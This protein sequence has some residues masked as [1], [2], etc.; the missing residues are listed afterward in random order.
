ME[1][2]FTF[3][4]RDKAIDIIEQSGDLVKY[5]TTQNVECP[6]LESK[7]IK[8]IKKLGKGAAGA[9]AWS[10]EVPGHGRKEYVAKIFTD[11]LE[12]R[13]LKE[14]D[15]LFGSKTSKTLKEIAKFIENNE[16][17]LADTTIYVNGNDPNRVYNKQNNFVYVMDNA[18]M[19]KNTIPLKFKRFDGPKF[20]TIPVGSYICAE[21]RF[22]EYIIGVLC[23]NIFRSGV[24]L[25]FIDMFGFASCANA[26]PDKIKQ[27]VFMDKIDSTIA[28][29]V[30]VKPAEDQII[31]PNSVL[32]EQTLWKGKKYTELDILCVQTLTA[33]A[34][35]Q[36]HSIQHDD[37]H[38]DNVFL[39]K[40]SKKTEYNNR[41]LIDYP[42]WKH[43]IFDKEIYTPATRWVVKIG[44]FGLSVKYST[45]MVGN[46][47]VLEN[48]YDQ[49][50]GGGSW[51][52][53]WFSRA[54]DV[55]YFLNATYRVDRGSKLVKALLGAALCLPP[56]ASDIDLD[57]E[58]LVALNPNNSRPR[59]NMLKN[60]DVSA[61][62]VTLLHNEILSSFH[63]PS[64]K[65]SNSCTLATII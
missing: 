21:E 29:L 30:F 27:Y 22:S 31:D 44:D 11:K 42:V 39:E 59:M 28:K 18:K 12:N 36:Q 53:N 7:E 14:M 1:K 32:F 20:T 5:L 38:L 17:I 54:Y 48:G 3:Q 40:V 25:H 43:D 51:I 60:Y 37:L 16:G 52:P 35:M 10:I 8:L 41:F 61:N 63:S 34:A 6:L 26:I 55:L 23:G 2:S 47:N 56:L 64:N 4:G 65:Q 9:P 62:P 45:P 50:D 33:I 49:H 19:C 46:E 15:S 57:A 58:V 13:K 24:S